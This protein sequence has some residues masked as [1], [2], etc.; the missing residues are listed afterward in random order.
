MKS[1][2]A[3]SSHKTPKVYDEDEICDMC[4]FPKDRSKF[5]ERAEEYGWRAWR[6][7]GRKQTLI[8]W[9]VGNG[10]YSIIK[11]EE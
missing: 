5:F 8:V 6:V 7:K 1:R 4:G 10:G 11:K 2:Q 9:D 3:T